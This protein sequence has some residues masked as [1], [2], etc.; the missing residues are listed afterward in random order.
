V[1]ANE[2]GESFSPIELRLQ[3]PYPVS[4]H[5]VANLKDAVGFSFKP[6]GMTMTFQT[7][8]GGQLSMNG[9]PVSSNYELRVSELKPE[10][11]VEI[12][13]LLNSYRDPR[14]KPIPK[15]QEAFY[16][17]PES[18]P[19][20]TFIYGHFKYRVG[21]ETIDQE[22]YAP[23]ELGADETVT[24]GPPSPRPKGLRRVEGWEMEW[25]LGAPR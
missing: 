1:I 14:G 20:L 9:R 11:Q 4:T 15:G 16:S 10:G 3:F 17:V 7:L 2:G 6:V 5:E 12:L 24:L 8:G 22:Y 25:P 13:L 18:G 23:L 21:A 19:T